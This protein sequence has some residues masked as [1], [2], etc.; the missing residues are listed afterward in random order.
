MKLRVSP[1]LIAL[2]IV[3]SLA[4][5]PPASLQSVY[6]AEPA[7]V[8]AAPNP[9]EL[10]ASAAFCDGVTEIPKVECEA[11]VALYY[12]TNGAN[13]SYG[14]EWLQALAPCGWG[15]VSCSQ[16]HVQKLELNGYK[17]TGIIPPQLGNLTNLQY[18]SLRQNQLTGAIPPELG[19]LANLQELWLAYNQLAGAVPPQLGNLPNLH[20]LVLDNNQL[21]GAIPKELAELANLQGLALG[22]NQLTG[23]IPRE[24]VK[25][26]SLQWLYL[27]GNQL[28]GAIP[29]EL[30][31]L[32]NLQL[33]S[34][35]G[36]LLTGAI[37]PQ[38]GNLANLQKLV[39][40]QNQLT[41]TIPP[42]LGS[43]VNLT[44][45]FLSR[46][47]LTGAIPWE[48]A[49]LA[50]LQY[51]E[52]FQNQLTGAIPP[53]LGNL[54]NLQWLRLDGNQMT[55]AIPP[56]LGNLTNLQLLS[57]DGNLLTGAIPTELTK[58]A[59]LQALWLSGNQLSDAIPSELGNLANL[60]SLTLGG[61]QLTGAI[62]PQLGNLTNLEYLSLPGN[63]LTGAI[64]AQLGS[65]AK[66][67]VLY[68]YRNQLTGVIPPQLGNLAS[69]TELW[70]SG[71]QLSDAIP[72]ELGNL[73][74]LER[75]F[76]DHNRLS[77]AL[78]QGLTKLH[79]QVFRFNDTHLCEPPTAAFQSWL[80]GISDLSRTGLV[81]YDPAIDG[82]QFKNAAV[83]FTWEM[84]RDLFGA[85][86]VE[87]IVNG[88]TVHLDLADKYY[89]SHFE[90]T[91]LDYTLGKCSDKVGV[92]G[93]CLGMSASSLAFWRQPSRRPVPG[94]LHTADLPFPGWRLF[95]PPR[96]GLWNGTPTSDAIARF[97]GAQYS[98]QIQQAAVEQ[99]QLSVA[100]T[101][102]LI[103]SAI[104]NG[105]VSPYVLSI[106]GPEC[107]GHVLVPH[108]YDT[109]I[110]VT[111]LYVYDP[112]WPANQPGGVGRFVTANAATNTWSYDMGG[113]FGTWSSG[114]CPNGLYVVAAALWD[115]P[116]IP[117][118]IASGIEYLAASQTSHLR[119]QDALGRVLGFRDGAIVSEIPDAAVMA[120]LGVLTDTVAAPTEA[121]VIS[122]TFPIEVS[123]IYSGTAPAQFD[124]W[125]GPVHATVGGQPASSPLFQAASPTLSDTFRYDLTAE[126]VQLVWAGATG[127]RRLALSSGQ[128][129]TGQEGEVSGFALPIGG[130]AHL[131]LGDSGHMTFTASSSLPGYTVAMAQTGIGEA[132][133]VGQGPAVSSGDV[134]ATEV[135]WADPETAM[136]RVYH[137]DT[138]DHVVT[139]RNR[140]GQVYLPLVLQAPLHTSP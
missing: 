49:T 139:I 130:S 15:G 38:L 90:C 129:V 11:L 137:G 26:A 73:T 27:S 79:L 72:S 110:G 3:V 107:S 102:A 23:A 48:L 125:R 83:I 34:L 53:Q 12:S 65:L 133:F 94:F 108:R 123:L 76:L 134:Q 60:G 100:Q 47:Q 43:L 46:N 124:A 114:Q 68:L 115:S 36:N 39:L 37:P 105:L 20:K 104:D 117:L 118:W 17:L 56:E 24:L 98:A 64:P 59:H 21:S 66:L 93:N 103:T 80:S 5:G 91:P 78:P 9:S 18:L 120:S 113:S 116:P 106:H 7:A 58:L 121:Y 132:H 8:L 14:S 71:N 33:L 84:F 42:E 88:K 70:L 135:D 4:F 92:G 111:K 22:D 86:N 119:I 97:Q 16:G 35:G 131:A 57:L 51:L 1:V 122:G 40:V 50:H 77:G 45:L 30:G 101:L 109:A 29:S 28:T 75:L 19:N 127:S 89:R 31:N 55:G 126:W 6:S 136:V 128:G 82:Y 2:L 54:T 44:G 25:L 41:G 87:T 96:E 69:L 13:W 62:P 95:P 112:N 99:T 32:A 52:L 85:A 81:C 138:L 61:N 67:R 74:N 140:Y 63:Q 10:A